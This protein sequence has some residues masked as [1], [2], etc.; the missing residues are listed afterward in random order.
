[1][2][3]WMGSLDGCVTLITGASGGIGKELAIRFGENGSDIALHYKSNKDS[4][5]KIAETLKNLGTK[6]SLFQADVTNAKETEQLLQQTVE[7]FGKIDVLINNAGITRDNLAIRLSESDWDDVIATNLKGAFL[8]SRAA[9]KH[10]L[11]QRNGRIINM[12]S[13]VGITGNIGQANYTAA[14]AG[15][16]GLTKTLALEVASRGITVNALAPGFISTPMTE[17]LSSHYQEMIIGQIPMGRFGTPK[18]VASAATFLASDDASYITGQVL[19]ID[20]GLGR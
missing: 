3:V 19:A 16:I 5:E 1:M 4:A 8:C 20:G 9:I 17:N 6:V 10:M 13:I 2:E 15:L 11:R 14:K 18:D 12:S 7:S